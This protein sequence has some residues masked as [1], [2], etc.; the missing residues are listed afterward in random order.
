MKPDII[1]YELNFKSKDPQKRGKF[2]CY[3]YSALADGG[4]CLH[5]FDLD[6]K[7]EENTLYFPYGSYDK[8][9]TRLIIGFKEE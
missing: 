9:E 8:F 5:L 3:N 6:N 2:I 7:E 1:L 4:L